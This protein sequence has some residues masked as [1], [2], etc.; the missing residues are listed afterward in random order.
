MPSSI[1]RCKH[2]HRVFASDWH[3]CPDCKRLSTVGWRLLGLKLIAILLSA[4]A[5]GFTVYI[6]LQPRPGR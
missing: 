4:L 6:L 5:L 3:R 1:T 2:C